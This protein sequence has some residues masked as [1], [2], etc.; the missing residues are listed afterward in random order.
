[1]KSEIRN[2]KS[3]IRLLLG[4]V[5]VASV[6]GLLGRWHGLTDIPRYQV[7]LYGSVARN[8]LK[9]GYPDFGLAQIVSPGPV[10]PPAERVYY[11]S[12]P[13]LA[14]LLSS[15][16]VALFG[17]QTWAVLL[18]QLACGLA[19]VGVLAALAQKVAGGT[20]WAWALVLG[21]AMPM[22]VQYGG[23]FVDVIGPPLVLWTSLAALFYLRYCESGRWADYWGL[24]AASALG[25]WTAWPAYVLCFV[26][27]GH[28][29]VYRSRARR[30]AMLALPALAVA[31]FGGL[32]AYVSRVPAEQ[33]VFFQT[34][35]GASRG[36]AAPGGGAELGG[37]SVR[38]MVI[39]F[40][41]K[42]L[43]Q[44]SP[45]VLLALLW[46]ARRLWPA[47]WTRENR[48]E[49][50]VVLL[51][52]WP[53]PYAAAFPWIFHAH[54]YYHL[55]FLP[56]VVVTVGLVAE[57][58]CR[59][60]ARWRGLVSVAGV[61]FLILSSFYVLTQEDR[62]EP[63]AHRQVRWAKDLAAHTAFEEESALAVH[64]A[65]QMRFLADR[66][67]VEHFALVKGRPV[68]EPTD[69]LARLEAVRTRK[70]RPVSR[71]FA[72][73]GYPFGDADFGW[74]L[75]ADFPVAVC[76]SLAGF[77]IRESE[78]QVSTGAFGEGPLE[79]GGGLRLEKRSFILVRAAGGTELLCLGLKASGL[80][81][82]LPGDTLEWQV[83][84]VAGNGARAGVASMPAQAS[85]SYLVA[86]PKGW[87]RE[88]GSVELA[89]R[90]RTT[91]AASVGL[92]TRLWRF[93]LR[94]L[95]FRALGGPKPVIR[96]SKPIVLTTL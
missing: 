44:F 37:V 86:V 74:G 75:M 64:Y 21:A 78:R 41:T 15:A 42:F 56:A 93:A 92:A 25:L 89:L 4:L 52:L 48:R 32:V 29:F 13:P 7:G 76:G 59:R 45:L 96:T 85:A 6:Y 50:H 17:P 94:F 31:C 9:Y 57:E 10:L 61:V 66:P 33:H 83:A 81:E 8:Y 87:P 39:G 38:S 90:H 53:L 34:L 46:L 35:G 88:G 14:P 79:L 63:L 95:T 82:T 73:L 2:P 91:D 20:A 40:F 55:L 5:A 58:W 84:F 16:G 68:M 18:P 1:M 71:L 69:T 62:W 27:A 19:L 28:A 24:L 23:A 60:G 12:H 65:L 51:W 72:P 47:V 70:P 3:E 26:L 67:V 49:Q 11:P 54:P 80:P 77:D 30:A 43:V 36:W 22:A